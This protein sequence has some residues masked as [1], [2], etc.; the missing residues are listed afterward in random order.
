MLNHSTINK[1]KQLEIALEIPLRD[2]E[3]M[4][5]IIE[6]AVDKLVEMNRADMIDSSERD[7]ILKS[8]RE[9]I[10]EEEC[11]AQSKIYA[12]KDLLKYTNNTAAFL[13]AL[14]KNV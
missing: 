13:Q 8:L 3:E 12:C 11:E 10:F 6:S 5:S 2:L 14:D 9:I 1:L 4:K 7:F